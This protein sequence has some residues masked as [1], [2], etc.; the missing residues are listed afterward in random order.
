MS[1][2]LADQLGAE[3]VDNNEPLPIED[4]LP[5]AVDVQQEAVPAQA[6]VHMF[7]II[8]T[9]FL[10]FRIPLQYSLF[11]GFESLY[12]YPRHCFVLV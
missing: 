5:A 8:L 1:K 9:S 6:E 2:I 4:A 7:N 12:I 11:L 10:F 3:S